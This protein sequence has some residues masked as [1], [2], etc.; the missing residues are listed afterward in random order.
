MTSMDGGNDEQGWMWGIPRN[1][2]TVDLEEGSS[3]RD[4]RG[5]SRW[6]R[7]PSN[8]KTT[9]TITTRI[10][11]KMDGKTT[12][13]IST[14]ERMASKK[15][16]AM[17]PKT[18]EGNA[19]TTRRTTR[20]SHR[21]TEM[22]ATTRNARRWRK[23]RRFRPKDGTTISWTWI[24]PPTTW[25]E[26]HRERHRDRPRWRRSRHQKRR[27]RRPL[28]IRCCLRRHP[29]LHYHP[30]RRRIPHPWN[31]RPRRRRCRSRPIRL[32]PRRIQNRTT[33]FPTPFK[34]WWP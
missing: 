16:Q 21:P 34:K 19:T 4:C 26:R 6:R 2:D 25:T 23:A 24:F 13:T 11:T 9:T 20:R 31:S 17:L 3:C 27:P 29:G 1:R 12:T 14:L 28:D 15:R 8:G 22:S 10:S 30:H 33:I 5:S 7:L 18:M 32:R